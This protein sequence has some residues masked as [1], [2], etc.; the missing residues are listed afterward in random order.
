MFDKKKM[1]EVD[2]IETLVTIISD[3]KQSLTYWDQILFVIC[4]FILFVQIG[5]DIDNES[6]VA[7]VHVFL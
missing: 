7:I 4:C 1:S 5:Y 2:E 6:S 3:L